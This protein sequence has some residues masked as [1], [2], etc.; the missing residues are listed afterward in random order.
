[1]RGDSAARRQRIGFRLYA[2]HILTV[3]A[4]AGS[5]ILLGLTVLSAPW[6]V[7]R[8]LW[9]RRH[10]PLLRPTAAYLILLAISIA[11][12]YDP[13]VSRR[14]ASGFFH[15]TTLLLALWLVRAEKDARALVTAFVLMATLTGAYG[16]VQVAAGFDNLGNRITGPF[17]HYMTF[18]GV[19]LLADMLLLARMATAGWRG[20]LWPGAHPLWSWLALGVINATLLASLTRNAWIGGAVAVTVLLACTARRAL[21]VLVPAV[22][23]VLWLVPAGVSSRVTSIFDLT[24]PSNYDRLCM[25][26]AGLHMVA[27]RPLFGIGPEMVPHRYAIYRHPTAPRYWVPHLHSSYLNLAAE[28]GLAG[29]AAFLWLFLVGGREAL[30]R[31]RRE[32]GLTGPRADLYLGAFVALLALGVAGLFE[33]YWRDSEIQRVCL[34]LLALPFALAAPDASR[35]N[36]VE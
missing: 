18:S 14:A 33:D 10:V 20:R 34:F 15:F 32:G 31:L 24:E 1:M 9:R 29:L 16:L 22:A 19:L 3:F 2:S 36:P 12:S 6:T 4:L 28:R 27:E 23:L 25:T 5:N 17:S 7:Q 8:P 21:L 30:R 26:Y 11:L 35:K 13:E